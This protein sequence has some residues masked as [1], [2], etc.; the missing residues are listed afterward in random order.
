KLRAE[1]EK[2][3][4]AQ[5]EQLAADGRRRMQE[6]MARY[7]AMTQA[8]KTRFLD[9]RIDQAEERRRRMQNNGG[10]GGGP[11]FGGPPN[12]GAGHW[13]AGQWAGWSSTDARRP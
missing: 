13:R 9:Q 10:P 11:G 6:E 1:T 5:R 3:T 12:G 2:L 4:P 7:F 8:E